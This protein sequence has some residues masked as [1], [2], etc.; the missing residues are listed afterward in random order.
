[1]LQILWQFRAKPTK[2]GDFRR[3]YSGAGEWA[4]LFGRSEEYQGTILLQ[5]TSDPLVFVAI[6]RW[7]RR[8]SFTRFREQYGHDYEQLD[9]QCRE[10]TDQETLIGVFTDEVA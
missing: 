2:T 7:A 3:N 5:D 4:K 1:M 9:E 10:L 6:D 8:D